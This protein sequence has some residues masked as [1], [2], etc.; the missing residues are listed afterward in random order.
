MCGT[1]GVWRNCKNCHFRPHGVTFIP[2]ICSLV[3]LQHAGLRWGDDPRHIW[4]S[5]TAV[6]LHVLFTSQLRN[7][8]QDCCVFQPLRITC[9]HS[10]CEKKKHKAVGQQKIQTV[11][12]S[13][14]YCRSSKWPRMVC[15]FLC[16][17]HQVKLKIMEIFSVLSYFWL[18]DNVWKMGRQTL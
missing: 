17:I 11:S 1:L 8:I 6:V 3:I 15:R 13:S 10:T 18:W 9:R 7:P 2:A 12:P 14:S 16:H 4:L 5:P